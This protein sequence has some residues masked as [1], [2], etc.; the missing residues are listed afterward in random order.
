MAS[1]RYRLAEDGEGMS[2]GVSKIGR[3]RGTMLKKDDLPGHEEI[4]HPLPSP[5]KNVIAKYC[6][7][8]NNMPI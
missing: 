7:K 8:N 5:P 3:A 1:S 2:F 4:L 6:R